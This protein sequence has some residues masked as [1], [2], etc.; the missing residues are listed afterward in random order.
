LLAQGEDLKRTVVS[1]TKETTHRSQERE[2]ELEHQSLVVACATS[3]QE[4]DSLGSHWGVV[5]ATHTDLLHQSHP[6]RIL[7]AGRYLTLATVF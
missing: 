4:I 1:A 2:K 3:T 7:N 6:F 5:L